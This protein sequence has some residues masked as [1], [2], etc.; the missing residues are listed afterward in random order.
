MPTKTDCCWPENGCV[1]VCVYYTSY[2]NSSD[3]KRMKKNKV[4]GQG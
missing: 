4:K 1:R 3:L 2:R